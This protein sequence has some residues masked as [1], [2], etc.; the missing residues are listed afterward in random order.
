MVR[1][2]N[3]TLLPQ[4]E[5]ASLPRRTKTPSRR[6]WKWAA[7]TILA[8][9]VLTGLIVASHNNDGDLQISSLSTQ[10]ACPQYPA[11]KALS[12]EREEFENEIKNEINSEAFFDKSLKRLQGAIQI[13]TESFD[14]MGK[15]GNDSRWDIFQDFHKYLEE[16]FPL[17]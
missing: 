8:T 15:V 12:A 2:K 7:S 10:P 16:S 17:V 4:G 5:P 13:P 6:V 9:A 14:D 11:I 3:Y 1:V